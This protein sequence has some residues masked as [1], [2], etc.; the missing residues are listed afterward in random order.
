MDNQR[1]LWRTC[2]E[3]A[4]LTSIKI[5]YVFQT[6]E[7]SA[8]IT[9]H[10]HLKSTR[11][12]QAS[13]ILSWLQPPIIASTKRQPLQMQIQPQFSMIRNSLGRKLFVA[14]YWDDETNEPH[15]PSPLTIYLTALTSR[16]Y[17]ID[18]PILFGAY[19]Q[20]TFPI[21]LHISWMCHSGT[22]VS[23][24][25]SNNKFHFLQCYFLAYSVA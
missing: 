19:L 3:E 10:I 7:Y 15:K 24:S 1:P 5:N 12:Q 6:A 11:T 20:I 4:Q 8:S 14:D 2:F 21:Y 17:K 25:L 13:V 18:N 22:A 16:E 23:N 9:Q